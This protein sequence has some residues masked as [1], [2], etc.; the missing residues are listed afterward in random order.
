MVALTA[1]RETVTTGPWRDVQ[2]ALTPWSYVAKV[3]DAGGAPV[4]LPASPDAA[5]TVAARADALLL[6]GGPDVSPSSYGAAPG[7]HTEHW[8]KERDIVELHALTV[9]EER[10]I[11]VLAI[12]RGLQLLSIHRG[13]TL[14]QHLA[15]IAP[16]TPGVFDRHS[17]RFRESS[18]LYE[19]FGNVASLPCH[20]H[21]AI[22]RLGSGLA[23]TGWSRTDVIEGAEDPDAPFTVGIQAHPEEAA[24]TSALFGAFVEAARRTDAG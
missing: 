16:S 20:H 15:E 9:A 5:G 17:I 7:P 4:L 21:Q 6:T 12:C 22:D 11:P 2:A 24:G 1:G 18:R 8:D 3:T 13:G 23:A 14:H 10:G 19:A